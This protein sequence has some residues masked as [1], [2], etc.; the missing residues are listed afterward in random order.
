MRQEIDYLSDREIEVMVHNTMKG[1][2]ELLPYA[3]DLNYGWQLLK[4][5]PRPVADDLQQSALN[6]SWT[7]KQFSREICDAYLVFNTQE[8]A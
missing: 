6:N 8:Q 2:G 5:L 1:D 3:S 7:V 4:R